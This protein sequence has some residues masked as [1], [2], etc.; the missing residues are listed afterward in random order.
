MTRPMHQY[1]GAGKRTFRQGF[2]LVELL[3]VIAILGILVGLLSWGVN[4][5][6]I[7]ILKRAQTMEIASLASAVEAYRNKYGDYPPD[8]S[9]W[10]V[11]EAHLRKAFP[12]ILISELNLLNP[13]FTSVNGYIRN[14]NDVPY[15]TYNPTFPQGFPRVFD[16]AEALVFFLGGF[17]S[18]PQRPFTGQGGPFKS[19]PASPLTLIYNTQRENAFFEFN[20]NRLTLNDSGFST[21]EQIYGQK[22][23]NSNTQL[24]PDLLPVYIGN[25]PTILQGGVPIVYFDSRTYLIQTPSG[26]Y[27]NFYTPGTV[28][29]GRNLNFARPYL[30]AEKDKST[31]NSAQLFANNRTYQLLNSGYDKFYGSRPVSRVSSPLTDLVLF[32][33][34]SGQPCIPALDPQDSKWRFYLA[35]DNIQGPQKAQSKYRLRELEDA[36]LF[37]SAG[38]NIS[39]F[40]D[41]PTFAESP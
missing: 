8:G 22:I 17:S 1:F 34:P 15:E 27:F 19:N 4:A 39:N 41:G 26:A 7:S 25:G 38:D 9:S 21:D 18:D 28:G 12:N 2:T 6:R 11:V 31:S 35:Q 20:T 29:D 16:P 13:A 32:V 23:T 30:S 3:I 24:P 36:K 37:D 33:C 40:I 5:A 10:P 14:D